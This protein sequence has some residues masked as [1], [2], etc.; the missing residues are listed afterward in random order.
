MTHGQKIRRRQL[1]QLADREDKDKVLIDSVS[2]DDFVS[3]L[4][5]T[6][7]GV[8]DR[9]MGGVSQQ[10][11]RVDEHSGRRC[12]RLCGDVRLDNNGG[13][14]QM[15]LDLD[16]HGGPID[17]TAF[18]G[19]R[20]VVLGNA[21]RYSVHL[22]TTDVERPWQSYRAHF[23][24]EQQWQEIDLPFDSFVP[25]RLDAPLDTSALR[26]IGVVAIGRA[27]HADLCLAAI[28]LYT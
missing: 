13:F 21:Q 8:S 17:A 7:Q 16:P 28:E 19:V 27:F 24:A 5:T 26:R 9:V 15:A 25:H 11:L 3:N 20:L 10:S 18:T 2:R 6:W 23:Q 12:L 1:R 14:I 22:R 4:G